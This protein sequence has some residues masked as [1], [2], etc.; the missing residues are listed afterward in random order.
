MGEEKRMKFIH[1]LLTIEYEY[2]D[3]DKYKKWKRPTH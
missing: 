2:A 1:K 3:D